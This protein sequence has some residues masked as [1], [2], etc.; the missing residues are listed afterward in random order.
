MSY[1]DEAQEE[2]LNLV[3]SPQEEPLNL[4]TKCSSKS[5]LTVKPE[6]LSMSDKNENKVMK[7][8][9][10]RITN[11]SGHS[12]WRLKK[13]KRKQIG[14]LSKGDFRKK[15][16]RKLNKSQ[17]KHSN[18]SSYQ[19]DRIET[20]G[21]KSSPDSSTNKSNT[22]RM[23]GTKIKL[24]K[25]GDSYKIASNQ[26]KQTE[27]LDSKGDCMIDDKTK[28]TQHRTNLTEKCEDEKSNIMQEITKER[29]KLVDKKCASTDL[30]KLS[31]FMGVSRKL[32]DKP[33]LLQQVQVITVTKA[34]D[35]DG[36]TIKRK[37][38]VIQIPTTSGGSRMVLVPQNQPHQTVVNTTLSHKLPSNKT[39]FPTEIVN[40]CSSKSGFPQVNESNGK[41]KVFKIGEDGTISCLGT[42]EEVQKSGL[43]LHKQ[44]ES[45][46]QVQAKTPQFQKTGGNVTESN[47]ESQPNYQEA[48]SKQKRIRRGSHNAL[49]LSK[50]AKLLP[51]RSLAIANSSVSQNNS[52]SSIS[53]SHMEPYLTRTGVCRE[54]YEMTKAPNVEK[55]PTHRTR[56]EKPTSTL[57]EKPTSILNISPPEVSKKTDVSSLKNNSSRKS[58]ELPLQEN[59]VLVGWNNKRTVNTG[60]KNS[61][62]CSKNEISKK[63]EVEKVNKTEQRK[64][65]SK[66]KSKIKESYFSAKTKASRG[67]ERDE[68]SNFTGKRSFRPPFY[69]VYGMRA[70]EI[71]QEK[72]LHRPGPPYYYPTTWH[73][74]H[75][76][77]GKK[78]QSSA[79]PHVFFFFKS[80]ENM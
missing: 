76:Y 56:V 38:V 30:E 61:E 71:P 11:K 70:E 36:I 80:K 42:L 23:Q 68:N 77:P 34:K 10:S 22:S 28:A 41:R 31:N 47:T 74:G 59:K 33:S 54:N 67:Y 46:K 19:N 45:I 1:A 14:S 24:I 37:P 79:F 35:Q 20:E 4:S 78:L 55:N 6:P 12:L 73:A 25:V 16:N 43:F 29:G 62:K 39:N 52:H 65:R 17:I 32:L 75:Q 53:V 44:E 63:H 15:C 48:V 50:K 64:I 49:D 60:S 3:I 13:S 26:N 58:G 69:P 72:F 27:G 66:L 21:T 7:K 51:F 2:P 5:Q 8:V 18:T 57:Q 40:N 9:F